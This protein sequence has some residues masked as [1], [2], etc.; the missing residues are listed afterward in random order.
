MQDRVRL[1][2]FVSV[3]RSPPGIAELVWMQRHGIRAVLD[4]R[5][6]LDRA[7]PLS[8]DAEAQAA[9]ARGLSY[10]SLPTATTELNDEMLDRFGAVLKSLPKPVL[11]HCSSGRRA[12]MFA[13]TH[14][15]LEQGVPGQSML[16]MARRLDVIYGDSHL[17]GGF[18]G[19]ID[20]RHQPPAR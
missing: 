18:A 19:Y 7:D 11:V 17:Q 8:S 15:A 5:T 20:R 4:L 2:R 13:L 16:E 9:A 12:G 10:A 3:G 6:P 1:S 14:V